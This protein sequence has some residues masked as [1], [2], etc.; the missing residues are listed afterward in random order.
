MSNLYTQINQ[1][2]VKQRQQLAQSSDEESQT[3]N[4]SPTAP[5]SDQDS[6]ERTE[7]N[8]T[9]E[10]SVRTAE[11]NGSPA[12]KNETVVDVEKEAQGTPAEPK[13]ANS[14]LIEEMKHGVAEVE[15]P[16]ERYSFEIYSDQKER[17][18]EIKYR[19]EKRTSK[20]LPKSRIIREALDL[21][22]DQV[23]NQ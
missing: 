3:E 17:I 4:Q 18:L 20:R 8:R 2:A 11:P 16:T 13:S 22:F 21:Y 14:T 9:D 19:Y 23:L 10:R 7:K 12:L 15:R 6:Q 5:P 1:E